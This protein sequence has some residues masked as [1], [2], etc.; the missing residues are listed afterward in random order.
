MKEN[1][2]NELVDFMDL[3]EVEEKFGVRVDYL[4]KAARLGRL[5][6][7]RV[8]GR[9]GPHLCLA[10]DV[11]SFLKKFPFNSRKNNFLKLK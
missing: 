11:K 7:I 10:K 8:G 5:K 4:R 1:E 2:M 3:R 6:T 9:Q